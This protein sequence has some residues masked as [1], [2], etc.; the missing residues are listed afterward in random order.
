MTPED[1]ELDRIQ[2][3]LQRVVGDGELGGALPPAGFY[4]LE[5]GAFLRLVQSLP[6]GAGAEAVVRLLN[7]LPESERT[8]LYSQRGTET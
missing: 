1:D 8:T 3:E 2:V 6:D 7:S 4:L 5:P